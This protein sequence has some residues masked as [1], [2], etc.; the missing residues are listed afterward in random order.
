[1]TEAAALRISRIPDDV[2]VPT[3]G[4]GGA[5]ILGGDGMVDAGRLRRFWWY[6]TPV[7]GIRALREVPLEPVEMRSGPTPTDVVMPL[8]DKVIR[9]PGIG[10]KLFEKRQAKGPPRYRRLKVLFRA[11]ARSRRHSVSIVELG[12]SACD[13]D[14]TTDL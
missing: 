10:L 3:G 9:T 4:V 12:G 6:E 13:A 8:R 14:A 1:M 2:P 5:G 7:P 11:S